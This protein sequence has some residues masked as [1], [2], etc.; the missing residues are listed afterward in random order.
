MYELVQEERRKNAALTAEVERLRE[1]H[2]DYQDRENKIK[3]LRSEARDA[4]HL[5]FERGMVNA[6]L[7]RCAEMTNETL[8]YL[9]WSSAPAMT[10][11][12]VQL[13]ADIK[14]TL[15]GS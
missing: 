15:E 11:T 3:I 2:I 4:N 8:T 10:S 5:R 13:L 6:L 7:T 1:E 12:A 14:K 9:D